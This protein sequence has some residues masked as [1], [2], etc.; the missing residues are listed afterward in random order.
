ML[1]YS[2]PIVAVPLP[3]VISSDRILELS[4]EM[5]HFV[6]ACFRHM[7]PSGWKAERFLRTVR[8]RKNLALIRYRALNLKR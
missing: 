4:P 7:T 6:E 5:K 2:S 8:G 3:K 1:L